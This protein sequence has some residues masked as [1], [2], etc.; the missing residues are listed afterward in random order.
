MGLP[1]ILLLCA[2]FAALY[3]D[4]QQLAMPERR[5]TQSVLLALVVACLF[6]CALHD[7]MIGDFFCMTIG[8]LL[9]LRTPGAAPPSS[10]RTGA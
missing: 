3:R 7:A 8:L 9:A 4:S 2:L 5:A 1:G 10:L 6:N